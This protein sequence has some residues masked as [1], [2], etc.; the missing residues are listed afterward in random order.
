MFC[1][2]W[3]WWGL[4]IQCF[5]SHRKLLLENL[6]L[7]QQLTVFKRKHPKP[8]LAPIDKFFWVLARRFWSRWKQALIVVTSETVVRWHRAGF[9][10]YWKLISKVRNRVGRKQRVVTELASEGIILSDIQ[11]SSVRGK[12]ADALEYFAILYAPVY[13]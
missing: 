4:L 7:R 11:P 9:H 6:A 1:L 5:R 12:D 10:L 8:K 13:P 3:L 2:L